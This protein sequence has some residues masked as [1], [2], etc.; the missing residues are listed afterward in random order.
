M[1]KKILLIVSSLIIIIG[2]CSCGK[3]GGLFSSATP[4][5]IPI[6][7]PTDIL[8]ANEIAEFVNYEPVLDG[9]IT[10]QDHT[11]TA[12]YVSNPRG[13]SDSVTVKVTQFGGNFTK[14]D[15]WNRYDSARVKRSSAELISGI[16]SDA[17][18]AFPSIHIYDRGCEITISAGSGSDTG[19]ANLLKRLGERAVMNFENIITTDDEV[20]SS[21]VT[22]E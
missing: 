8:P 6:V 17:Y 21:V 12:V 7:S 10:D 3:S 18:I 19:Q 22:Q 15:V 9:E 2:L 4:T 5:P 1:T 20:S 16:G 13:Q 11:K 14:D